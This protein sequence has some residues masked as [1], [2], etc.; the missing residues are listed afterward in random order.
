MRYLVKARVK[1]GQETALLRAIETESLGKGSVAGDEYLENMRAARLGE[2]GVATWVEVCFCS[3]PL[4][5][6]RPYWEEYFELESVKDAHS[7]RSCRD[8]N[9]SEPW[10]CC[11]CDCTKELE[12]R[13]SQRGVSFLEKLRSDAVLMMGAASK[14]KEV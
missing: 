10:A 11:N 3:T 5:E 8:L 9:G 6:E 1:A 13:L 4:A 2:D 7:R 12:A 14:S